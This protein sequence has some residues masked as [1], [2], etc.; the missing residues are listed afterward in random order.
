MSKFAIHAALKFRKS[1]F[2]LFYDFLKASVACGLISLGASYLLLP[3]QPIFVF[4]ISLITSTLWIC[5]LWHLEVIE[6]KGN[7]LEIRSGFWFR[8]KKSFSME[9]I[10]EIK[11]KQSVIGKYLKY[12]DLI[13]TAPTIDESII[14]KN[15]DNVKRL[16]KV[17]NDY[18]RDKEGDGFVI[19]S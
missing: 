17:L 13:I 12:G 19:T 4:F 1:V 15:L 3:I 10:Q 8:E 9:Y 2:S 11:V 16:S 18:A 14:I 7:I 6:V 5:V